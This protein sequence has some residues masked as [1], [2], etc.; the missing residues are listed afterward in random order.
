MYKSQVMR[1]NSYMLGGVSVVLR[2][3]YVGT[4]HD[5]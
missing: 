3:F 2:T 1:I 5:V 4:F